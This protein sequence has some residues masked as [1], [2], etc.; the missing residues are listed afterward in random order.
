[1]FNENKTKEETL[2][3]NYMVIES[4]ELCYLLISMIV[5][6]KFI[7]I[8]NCDEMMIRKYYILSILIII[9]TIYYLWILNKGTNNEY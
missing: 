7:S 6:L 9:S 8:I 5:I 4:Q 3:T 1:M 2:K